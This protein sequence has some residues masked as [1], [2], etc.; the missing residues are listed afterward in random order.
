[1]KSIS[2]FRPFKPLCALLLALLCLTVSPSAAQQ[3]QQAPD[4]KDR[5]IELL[6]RRLEIL[7]D[8]YQQANIERL[9]YE[10]QLQVAAMHDYDIESTVVYAPLDREILQDLFVDSIRK[11]YPGRTFDLNIWFHKL[12]GAIPPDMDVMAF[13][14]ELLD[15]QAGGLYD[16][17]SGRLYVNPAFPLEGML[18]QTI[19]AHEINHALQDQNFDLLSSGI[20]EPG[21]SD[22][23]AALGALIE[24]DATLTMTEYMLRH[25]SLLKL[26]GD[27]PAA[28]MID[29]TKLNQAPELIQRQLLFPYIEGANFFQRLNGRVRG[30]GEV[31]DILDPAWRNRVFLNPPFTTEQILHPEKYLEGET[32]ARLTIPESRFADAAHRF[33]DTL[34]EFGIATLLQPVL[35]DDQANAA[36]AGWNGDRLVITENEN[37]TRRDFI[38]VLAGD[39][40]T[41][42]D[43]LEAALREAFLNAAGEDF[44]W[45]EQEGV[46]TGR[47]PGLK[48]TLRRTDPRTVS[49]E[50]TETSK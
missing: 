20:W 8:K 5:E 43:E 9:V 25:G 26:L 14:Q 12:L 40:E 42:A 41:D 27:L 33:E 16:P 50:G 44:A 45:A 48:L 3:T 46:T 30:S 29:Q 34:G 31:G 4:L 38:W 11:Q 10:I 7:E 6:K 23:S 21:N 36:A 28:A 39:T 35:G 17:F 15:E 24:G 2:A 49:I 1:M 47:A 13:M 37:A 32:P 18:G 19:L 22:R